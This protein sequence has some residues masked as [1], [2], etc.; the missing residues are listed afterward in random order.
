MKQINCEFMKSFFISVSFLDSIKKWFSAFKFG[1]RTLIKPLN[2]DLLR[3]LMRTK[4][5]DFSWI[6]TP[7]K[8]TRGGKASRLRKCLLALWK[9]E[10]H[11]NLPWSSYSAALVFVFLRKCFW[12]ISSCDNLLRTTARDI[13]FLDVGHHAAG[14][15]D[16]PGIF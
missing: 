3:V 1:V 9:H 12:V 13:N 16:F 15:R 8:S 4:L 5:H 11:K 14:R 7:L 10:I 2:N 6:F